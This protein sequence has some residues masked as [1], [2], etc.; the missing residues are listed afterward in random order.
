MMF[1]KLL[2]VI[3]IFLLFFITSCARMN[4]DRVSIKINSNPSRSHLYIN[5]A[6]YGQTPVDISLLPDSDINYKATI[7]GKN[8]QKTIDLETWYSVRE[9][10]GAETTRCVL[11]AFGSMFILPMASFLSI[12]CRDFKQKEY[13]IDAYKP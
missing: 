13:F 1:N 11:D 4:E 10:R 3:I 6:Y 9:G 5:N 12:K 2:S 8:Y 7:M